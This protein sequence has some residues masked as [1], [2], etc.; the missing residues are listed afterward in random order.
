MKCQKFTRLTMLFY[1]LVALAFG[2]D[3]VDSAATNQSAA[4]PAKIT[5]NISANPAAQ[6]ALD[7]LQR[8]NR[9]PLMTHVSRQTRNYNFVRASSGVL[10]TADNSATPRARALAFLTAHGGLIGMTTA[11]CA[12]IGVTTSSSAGS[13]L[14]VFANETDSLGMT[15]VK[16]NQFYQGI[17][18]FGAQIVVHMRAASVRQSS[19]DHWTIEFPRDCVAHVRLVPG[20][21]AIVGRLRPNEELDVRMG[22][23]RRPGHE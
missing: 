10:A 11:E 7:S 12:A 3:S 5:D 21:P 14:E 17:P 22:H 6:M 9:N 19:P 4:A 16:L 15:H 13:K 2:P 23:E 18:V 1:F 20:K 8:A